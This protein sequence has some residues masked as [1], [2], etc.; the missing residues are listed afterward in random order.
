MD[1]IVLLFTD[2]WVILD[3]LQWHAEDSEVHSESATTSRFPSDQ[4]PKSVPPSESVIRLLLTF[5][6]QTAAEA[7]VEVNRPWPAAGQSLTNDW[8]HDDSHCN[9]DMKYAAKNHVT[10]SSPLTLGVSVTFTIIFSYHF[11]NKPEWTSKEKNVL[12][13]LLWKCR[14]MLE[15]N[16]VIQCCNNL[17]NLVIMLNTFSLSW[18]EFIV[19]HLFVHTESVRNSNSMNEMKC[20]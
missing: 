4:L 10:K 3:L 6:Q 19:L 14:V 8:L 5:Q 7:K 11:R 17:L 15:K 20:N 1:L 16:K 2:D 13:V 12:N 18:K 9:G